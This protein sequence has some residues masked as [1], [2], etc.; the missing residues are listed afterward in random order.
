[1]KL[2]LFI[3]FLILYSHE[4][5]L[6]FCQSP[7]NQLVI[8]YSATD[9]LIER[10]FT[11]SLLIRDSDSRPTVAFPDIP[12]L[13]KQGIARS[14]TRSEA[15]GREVTNQL[16][17][18]TYLATQA[19]TIKVPPFTL[20]V[21][22]QSVRSPGL[23][24]TVRSVASP[25]ETAALA[26]ANRARNDEQAAFL[27]TSVNQTTVYTGEGLRIRLSFF[28]A[29]NY[30]YEVKFEQLEQQLAA[31]VRKLKPVNAWEENDNISE[32][33][34]T[35]A[36]LNGRNYKEYRLYEA[37]FFLLTTRA[38]AARQLTLPALPLTVSRRLVQPVTT[39]GPAGKPTSGTLAAEEAE[40]VTFNSQPV[41]VQVRPL[42]QVSATSNAGQVSVGTFRLM[43]NVDQNR[44]AVGQ[45]VR[46]DIRV[47]GQGNIAGIQAPQINAS[48]ADLDIFPPQVQSVV[49]RTGEQVSGY[50]LF[51]Y[52]LIPKQKGRLALANRFFWVYF[53]PQTSRYDTLRPQT[54][55]QVG[56]ASEAQSIGVVPSDTLDRSGRP[57]IYAG[58]EQIKSTD[59]F[60]NWPVL[61]RAIAN[62]LIV[63][64][65]LGTLFVFARK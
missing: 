4:G 53:N 45:S 51:R 65:M 62:V 14:A 10:S 61:I 37:T 6:V 43:A 11:I 20:T 2:V 16:L 21:N 60:I 48:E 64:M 58:L 36:L 35:P 7:E 12:G 31:I 30:P 19:G 41:V 57:S 33:R 17:V 38:G 39:P 55:L 13:V 24:L 5:S 54:M 44:V 26:A 8:D 3:V 28:V 40:A 18:Q 63:L 59:P 15:G 56:E 9:F 22:G 32:L 50:K 25:A 52:Y 46:C 23:T 42:P 1:M 34:E 27:K 47:E 29:E 49:G